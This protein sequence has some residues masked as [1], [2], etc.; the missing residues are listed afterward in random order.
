[1]GDW[2]TGIF[3]CFSDIKILL[4]SWLCGTCNIAYQKAAIEGHECGIGDLIPVLFCGI[5]CMVQVRGKIREKYGIDGTLINDILMSL[6]C[7]ICAIS[8][9]TRQL[10]MKGAK[11]AGCFMDK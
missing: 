11:P 4:I 2:D 7:G 8:Q 6:C 10:D 1:M 3:D 5:C 9:Q